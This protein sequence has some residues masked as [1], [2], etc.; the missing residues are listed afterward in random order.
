L[1]SSHSPA[2]KSEKKWI[3]SD[4]LDLVEYRFKR[5]S[6]KEAQEAP[7]REEVYKYC[8]EGSDF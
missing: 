7:I 3:P 2:A 4:P 6:E 5:T 1:Q 8:K